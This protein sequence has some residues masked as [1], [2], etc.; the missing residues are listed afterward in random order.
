[1]PTIHI[2]TI[3]GLGYDHRIF[4]H[5]H[6]PEAEMQ[7]LDWLEP[8]GQESLANYAQRMADQIPDTALPLVLI[9][10]SFGGILC[11][12]IAKIR[13]VALIFLVSTIKSRKELPL[14]FK[15]IQ[16]FFLYR[17]M[18]KPLIFASF[19]FWARRHGFVEKAHRKLFRDMIGR[20]SNHYLQWALKALSN[21]DNPEPATV[22]VVQLHGDQDRTFPIQLLQ[23]GFQKILD[24]DH[25]MVLKKPALLQS[26]LTFELRKL[27]DK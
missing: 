17:L 1:M 21:W 11:Q 7:H 18:F 25:L 22:P 16:R 9:G 14:Q 4:E 6:F 3:P 2:A 15:L 20:H 12:E 13:P 5:L 27:R 8:N 24:A 23:T 10:H 19:P 26:I